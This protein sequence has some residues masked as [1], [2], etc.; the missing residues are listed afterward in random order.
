MKNSLSIPRHDRADFSQLPEVVKREV[1]TWLHALSEIIDAPHRGCAFSAASRQ[2][3]C[4]LKTVIRKYYAFVN[5]GHDWRVLVNRAKA[6]AREDVGLP[7]EIIQ[8]YK[9]Y[10]ERNQR[11]SAPAHRAMMRDWKAGKLDEFVFD[12]S[13][14]KINWPK[15]DHRT[16]RPTGCTYSNLQRQ[17][18]APRFDL[19]IARIGRTAG[20]AYRPLVYTGRKGL[21]VMSHCML[22]DM[23]HDFFVNSLAE[24]QAGRPLELFSHDLY[25]AR[26][27]RW[28]VRIRT[29]D[30]TGKYNGLAE[31]MTRYILAATLFEV[32]YSRRGTVIVAEHGT[33]AVDGITK[34]GKFTHTIRDG[35]DKELWE[36]SGGLITVERSGMTGAAAAAGQYSGLSKGNFRMKASLESSNNLVHNEFAALPAQTGMS[37]ERRPEQLN[38]LLRHNNALLAAYSLLPEL[39][40]ERL[41]FPMLEVNQFMPIAIELYRHIENYTDH[42]LTDWIECGHVVNEFYFDGRWMDQRAVI[43]AA[44]EVQDLFSAML[45]SGRIETR[46]R[47]MS[48]REAWDAGAG[49]LVKL[50]GHGVVA[51]LGGDLAIERKVKDGRFEFTDAEVGP[52]LHRYDSLAVDPQGRKCELR[53]GE[54]YQAFVN[55][56]APETLFVCNARGGYIGECKRIAT[57]CRG[58]EEA[59][60]R[61]CGAA[62]KRESDLLNPYRLRHMAEAREKAARHKNNAMALDT[63]EPKLPRSKAVTIDELSELGAADQVSV[64]WPENETPDA[65]DARP[66]SEAEI[67]EL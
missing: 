60:Q 21:W 58:D 26:K 35:L 38:G 3:Q 4:S 48:R 17:A 41:Q 11:K 40:R 18:K 23:W 65:H 10:T 14:V 16:G 29:R 31:R 34:K 62:A 42:N 63:S 1:H 33:A 13:P 32:G 15:V 54:V 2:L 53:E 25:S 8:L 7:S 20:A 22:D 43:Q 55:P 30:E 46:S 51:I 67:F 37:V 56:F 12:R 24:K 57:A 9:I 39:M 49:E 61:A 27:I 44:P 59:V 45:D 50:P 66:V 52:G 36:I 5:N 28:G 6:P 64:A 47:P 19:T